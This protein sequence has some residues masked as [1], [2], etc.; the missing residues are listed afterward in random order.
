MR[1]VRDHP[2]MRGEHVAVALMSLAHPGSSPH[3]RGAPVQRPPHGHRGGIIPACAGSTFRSRGSPNSPGD[4][5]RM[6]GEHQLMELTCFSVMGSS[7][8]ARGAQR[9]AYLH[10]AVFGIIPA[11]AGSTTAR[12]WPSFS[13][14]D[15]PRMRGEHEWEHRT[16]MQ[17]EGS[18]PHAR[19]APTSSASFR[20]ASGIIPAC[21]GSTFG[22]CGSWRQERDHPRMRGE[23]VM[24]PQIE[25]GSEGSSPHARGALVTRPM[26]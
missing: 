22:K 25:V 1:S 14:W 17:L 24:Y 19:G 4:H 9:V 10:D 21:A 13:R 20:F 12:R 11:C 18:S 15:H 2:R 16:G 6:R 26:L 3:A 8:H 23:H 7:P 5:P